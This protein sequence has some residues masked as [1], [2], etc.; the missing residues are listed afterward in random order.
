M[1]DDINDYPLLTELCENITA[2]SFLLL[3]IPSRSFL[4][5]L[6]ISATKCSMDCLHGVMM[7]VYGVGVLI[8]ASGIG[9]SEA[10]LELI[11]RGGRF[12]AD[13]LVKIVKP[14]KA[15]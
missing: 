14:T 4:K 12:V 3:L 15:R 1:G 5:F 11:K 13:D 2:F 7:E 6:P 8:R 9:K 10:A